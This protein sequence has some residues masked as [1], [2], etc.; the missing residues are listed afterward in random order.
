TTEPVFGLAALWVPAGMRSQAEMAGATVVDPS[1]VI[2]THL[3]EIVK[4]HAGRL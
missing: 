1:S 2:T 4:E 3:A